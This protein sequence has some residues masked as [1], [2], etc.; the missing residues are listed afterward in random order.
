MELQESVDGTTWTMVETRLWFEGRARWTVPDEGPAVWW[1]RLAPVGRPPLAAVTVRAAPSQRQ[2]YTWTR[3]LDETP[4]AARDGAGAL[5]HRDRMWL[6]GGWNPLLPD[7]YP[8]W[9]NNEVWSSA[10]GS[11]WRLEKPNTFGT[12]A[13]DAARDWEGRHTAGYAVHDDRMWLVGGDVLQGHYQRDA[14][15]SIDGRTWVRELEGSDVP[16]RVL[17]YTVGFDA[18]LW[19]MGGQTMPDAASEPGPTE[20]FADAWRLEGRT[21]S[22]VTAD[23]GWAPRGA[24]VGAAT[25]DGKMWLVGGGTYDTH[26]KPTREYYDDV[27]S[28]PDGKTW[29]RMDD[30]STPWEA[31]EY[32][33]VVVFDDRI[34]VLGGYNQRGNLSDVWFTRDGRNWYEVQD[35]PWVPRHAASTWAFRGGLYLAAG[36]AMVGKVMRSDVWRLDVAREQ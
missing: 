27:W 34:F 23:P 31:R 3:V 33:N 13:F 8:R 21:W 29:S 5:V 1:L 7:A 2:R 4:F 11:S 30:G 22:R 18:K 24:I 32:A 10:D 25:L 19:V 20:L 14:W 17:H 36:N 6:I 12:P 26:D 15:S 28:T 9:C 16:K 35:T